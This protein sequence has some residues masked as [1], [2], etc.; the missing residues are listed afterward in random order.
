MA[1]RYDER[2]R[3]E[4][5]RGERGYGRDERGLAERAGDQIRSWVGDDD[6]R[7]RRSEVDR[8][9]DYAWASGD[10]GSPREYAT[11]EPSERNWRADRPRT[12]QRWSG[13][14]GRIEY[15][16]RS[17]GWREQPRYGYRPGEWS[18]S[19]DAENRW[20][21]ERQQP[22]RDL[23]S[24]W[25]TGGNLAG[26]GPRGY[27]R[28]DERIMEDVCDRLTDAPDVDASDIEVNVTNGEVTLGGSVGD[29]RQ[30]RRSEDLIENLSGVREVHNNLRVARPDTTD[31]PSASAGT[32]SAVPTR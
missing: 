12:G 3:G 28:S 7:R 2:Y 26:R 10:E 31:R 25:R 5:Y 19:V 20:A 1:E 11:H 13:D 29:R 22:M 24:E 30:K 23:G 4:T 6:A 9:S 18:S 14:D 16:A 15:D 32:G 17:T 27:R 21:N 8:Q